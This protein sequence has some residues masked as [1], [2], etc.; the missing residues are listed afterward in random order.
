MRA[1]RCEEDIIQ[2]L[3]DAGCDEG[4][5]Q[6]F[7]NDLQCG[8]QIEGTHLLQ[9]HRRKLLDHLHQ[10]QRKID[11]LDYLLFMLNKEQKGRP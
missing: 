4:V 10:A 5:I 11:C 2:N 8:K 3:K 6:T 1:Y 9:K 7:M